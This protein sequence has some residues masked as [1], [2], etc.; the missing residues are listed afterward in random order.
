MRRFSFPPNLG[1]RRSLLRAVAAGLATLT[2]LLILLVRLPATAETARHYT[3]LKFPP[4]P[5]VRFP[6][7][8]R[9][10]LDN[11][12]IVYLVEDHELPLVQGTAL[13]R[14]GD[15]L[16][17]A[18]KVGLAEIMGEVMRTGGTRTHSAD[19]LNQLLEQ[20]AAA[21]ET[22]VST[23]SGSATFDALSEDLPQV[24]SL[25][26]EVIREP[27]FAQD[28]IDLAKTQRRGGI[29]RRNDDPDEI[30]SREFQ[31]LVYGNTSPYAR[32]LE[33][34]TLN[35]INREDIVKFYQQYFRPSNMI[36]G[37]IGDFDRKAM[38]S[39]IQSKFGNWQPA[40]AQQPKLPTVSQA[41]VGGVFLVNQPQLTQSYV[42][43]GHL[44]GQLS[45]PDHAALS[46]L[47]EV[48]GGFGRR[49]F[50]QVRS[51]Q[52]LAY[53]VY[54]FW[55]PQYDYPGVFVAGGQ[56]RSETTVPFIKSVLQEIEQ[57]RTQPVSQA[58][59]TSAKDT[60][61]NSF[62]FNFADP[63]QSLARLMRYEYYGYPRDFIFQY[64]RGV[65]AT[66]VADLQRVAQKH[67]KPEDIVTL[68]VGNAAAIRP[69]LTSLNAKTKVTPVDISI[70][71]PASP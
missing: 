57:L 68:V 65:E 9:Y 12:I 55:S 53:S 69:P 62:V 15:R 54:G 35:N 58:E 33:Y 45:N 63:K 11:G 31:K 28:K 17:P 36:L 2:V 51:R 52:G 10:Q 21:V 46:V 39:L 16:E 4:V 67:L 18:N 29:A 70:P 48:L 47:N 61:L 40:K 49:L 64:R 41:K 19:Q 66:T 7:Y 43:M 30:A 3:E 20:Q 27:V 26:A 42:Q 25:F 32:T 34:A 24:F 50:N 1:S 13:F 8:T 14:T 71:E 23:T 5:E 38:R 22:G 59:L 44:G 60:V 6:D 56:T 37:V